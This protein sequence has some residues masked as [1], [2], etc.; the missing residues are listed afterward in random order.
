ME[1][2]LKK[3]RMAKKTIGKMK[4]EAEEVIENIKNEKN[5]FLRK[6]DEILKDDLNKI[7]KLKKKMKYLSDENNIEELDKTI[8]EILAISQDDIGKRTQDELY[9]DSLENVT[10]S[11]K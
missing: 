1:N 8:K 4:D 2:F 11:D 10:E 5:D 6:T 3:L 9:F 7:D